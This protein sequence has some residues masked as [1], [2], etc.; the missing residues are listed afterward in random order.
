M[1]H[2]KMK[3]LKREFNKI[4]HGSIVAHDAAIDIK[5]EI[6]VN[7]P[8]NP[9]LSTETNKILSEGID[10]MVGSGRYMRSKDFIVNNIEHLY[11]RTL[12]KILS[13]NVKKTFP[14][15]ELVRKTPSKAV[16]V[17]EYDAVVIFRKMIRG[18]SPEK[19]L[20]LFPQYTRRQVLRIKRSFVEKRTE[21]PAPGMLGALLDIRKRKNAWF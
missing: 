11:P 2:S 20:E 19:I 17:D 4:V 18:V 3:I 12:R 5:K 10:G 15:I 14:K 13:K 8:H 21:R 6:D 16:P 7:K 1:S 9:I